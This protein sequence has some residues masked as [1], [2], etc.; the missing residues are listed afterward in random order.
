MERLWS[1]HWTPWTHQ[2]RN[3][4]G[5]LLQFPSCLRSRSI[6]GNHLAGQQGFYACHSCH[7]ARRRRGLPTPL[8]WKKLMPSML[9]GPHRG[10]PLCLLHW[11]QWRSAPT[12]SAGQIL[13]EN[14]LLTK[15]LF[16]EE[17]EWKL[18]GWLTRQGVTCR[19]VHHPGQ[20][21]CPSF[22]L[23]PDPDQAPTPDCKE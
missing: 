2:G 9:S 7:S 13:Q 17:E 10:R 1:C 4:E 21:Y 5:H 12:R 14:R 3:N 23:I 6:L 20:C 18:H 8:Q 16:P 11:I 19:S 15:W 22:K